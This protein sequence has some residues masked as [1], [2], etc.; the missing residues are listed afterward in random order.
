MSGCGLVFV[1]LPGVDLVGVFLYVL[2]GHRLRPV[3]VVL[4]AF[5][6]PVLLILK[7]LGKCLHF[8]VVGLFDVFQIL[9]QVRLLVLVLGKRTPAETAA[10]VVNGRVMVVDL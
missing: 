9:G 4:T 7:L 1:L 6:L 8:G 5:P 3:S 2:D 10:G